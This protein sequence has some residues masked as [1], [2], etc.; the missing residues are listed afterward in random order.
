MQ[1][2]TRAAE[3]PVQKRERT[4]DMRRIIPILHLP[5][6]LN[7]SKQKCTDGVDN[8]PFYEFLAI[9]DSQLKLSKFF[10]H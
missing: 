5:G 10:L 4:A 9:G 6:Y 1:Q 8:S 2:E 7:I 3:T